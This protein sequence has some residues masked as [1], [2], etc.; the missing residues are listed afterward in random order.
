MMPMGSFTDAKNKEWKDHDGSA[1][2]Y[3]GREKTRKGEKEG[4]EEGRW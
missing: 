4:K 2:V 1:V 3:Y